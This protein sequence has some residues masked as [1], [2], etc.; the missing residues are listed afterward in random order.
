MGSHIDFGDPVSIGTLGITSTGQL[1]GQDAAD[2]QARSAREA[3]ATQAA[4]YERGI[5]EQRRQFDIQQQQLRPFREIGL[6]GLQQYQQA[7]GQAPEAVPQL[8][9]YQPFQLSQLYQDP[10]YQ[11]R[12]QQGEQAINRA[13]AARGGRLSGG[14]LADLAQYGQGL[15]SQEYEAARNR[16]LQD[17]GLAQQTQLA[18]Y[19]LTSG[20]RSDYLN[21]L[22]ALGGI[23]QTTSGQLADLSSQYAAN[24]GNLYGQQGQAQA[25]GI[26]GAGQAQAAGSLGARNLVGDIAQIGAMAYGAR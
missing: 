6:S 8:A 21:R 3:A 25:Q 12:L 24:L 26:L 11:F 22:A 15:A 19:G 5:E 23:G 17:Y 18:Q 14:T 7:I 2:I 9:G 10:G 4:A 20:A 1:T 13:A 16:Y